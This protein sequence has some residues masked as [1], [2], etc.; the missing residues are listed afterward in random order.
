MFR[1]IRLNIEITVNCSISLKFGTD[2]RHITGD[3]LQMF[4]VKRQDHSVP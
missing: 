1:V 3:A 2:F 4:K